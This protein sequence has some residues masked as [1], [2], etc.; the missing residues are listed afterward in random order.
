MH[1]LNNKVSEIESHIPAV[2]Q[3]VPA[4]S[5]TTDVNIK[6]CIVKTVQDI[7]RRDSNVVVTGFPK[8]EHET[9]DEAF[10]S[11]CESDLAVKPV[12]VWY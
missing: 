3:S 7:N 2:A 4:S 10:L 11:F 5:G 8:Q 6:T 9:D 12:I 1:K